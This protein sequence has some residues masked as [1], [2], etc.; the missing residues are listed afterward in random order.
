MEV[1]R[2]YFV[3]DTLSGTI[4]KYKGRKVMFVDFAEI[5]IIGKT[6][7]ES[8]GEKLDCKVKHLSNVTVITPK[9]V[10]KYEILCSEDEK[11]KKELANWFNEHFLE[12]AK[13]AIGDITI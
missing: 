5:R 12:V 3:G 2:R 8:I 6:L 9:L 1:L 7:D 10:K 11:L 4:V 13:L